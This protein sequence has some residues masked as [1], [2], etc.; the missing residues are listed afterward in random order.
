MACRKRRL[1]YL[2]Y[3]GPCFTVA[4]CLHSHVNLNGTLHPSAC[5]TLACVVSPLREA[6]RRLPFEAPISDYCEQALV[7]T[8]PSAVGASG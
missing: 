4:S 2:L 8:Y 3:A 5:L 7:L 6:A 1:F